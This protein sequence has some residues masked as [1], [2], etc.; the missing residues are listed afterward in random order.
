MLADVLADR[1]DGRRLVALVS[2]GVA[3]E[4]VVMLLSRLVGSS[5]LIGIHAVIA[6]AIAIAVA[7]A[8]G[9]MAGAIVGGIGAVLF[10][11]LIGYAQTRDPHL[12]GLPVVLLWCGLPI[13]AGV[14]ADSLRR[15]AH[16]ARYLAL[17]AATRAQMLQRAVGRLAAATTPDEVARIAVVEGSAA[18][19]AQGAWLA[20][21]DDR[22]TVLDYV[23]SSGFSDDWIEQFLEIPLDRATAASDVVRDGAARFFDD[24]AAMSAAYPTNAA[25]YRAVDL[26]ATAVLP[27]SQGMQPVGMIAFHWRQPHPF[28]PAER[29]IALTFG[30]AAGQ[31]LERARLYAEVSGTAEALQR[32]LLP[33]FLPTFPEYEIA[34]RYRPA[35]ETLAVGGD[36]YDVVAAHRGQIGIAVGDVGGKG[37]E[38][39][40]IMGRLRTAMRAYAIEHAAPSDVLRRLVDYH[41]VTRPDVFATVVYAAIDRQ[42]RRLRVASLGH[43]MP[44]LVRA[45]RSV[46]LPIQGD[47][48]LG[49]EAD[50]SFH[51][52]AVP[53]Q[54]G[55]LLIFVTDGV[56]ERPATHW[57]ESLDQL[58]AHAAADADA[59]VEVLADRLIGSINDDASARDDRVLVV[60]RVP[61]GLAQEATA[62]EAGLQDDAAAIP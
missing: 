54:E 25:A 20:L 56:F 35:F 2:I 30:N 19:G 1:F 33:A 8:G 53:V 16:R 15:T 23:A 37:I 26:E 44:L 6:I 24:A 46:P 57:D 49:A 52:L 36:W 39:A 10:V 17:D 29:D 21:V 41:A 48:P 5:G 31:A 55:D 7:I 47:A 59:P 22:R 18:L 51:E 50:R 14:A 40:A 45:G 58:A 27:L 60:I 42:Q 38:A 28:T 11:V 3:L 34:V 43:P 32:S 4:A 61:R 9:P 12:Y 62:A 13:G